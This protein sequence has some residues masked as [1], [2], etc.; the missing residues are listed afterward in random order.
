MVSSPTA[1]CRVLVRDAKSRGGILVLIVVNALLLPEISAEVDRLR[2]DLIAEG[3]SS[4]VATLPAGSS[5][6][7]L[8]SLL[9]TEYQTPSQFMAGAV[10]IGAL[11]A[12]TNLDTLEH[13]DLRADG[14]DERR[15]GGPLEHEA[16]DPGLQEAPENRR[17][18]LRRPGR[19]R[20]SRRHRRLR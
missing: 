3:Y 7:A 15:A 11:P 9:R 8:W 20:A 2:I 16:R 13:T 10:L 17:H 4:K 14:V 12:A 6:A 19:R 5:G 1:T 18:P